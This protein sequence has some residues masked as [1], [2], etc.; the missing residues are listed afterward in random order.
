MYAKQLWRKTAISFIEL[1]QNP[2]PVN[3]NPMTQI[4]FKGSPIHTCGSLPETGAPAP[5]FTLV[6]GDL[7]EVALDTFSGKILVLNIV[8]SLDT[9]VCQASAR[10]FNEI[11]DG[12]DHVVVANVS[13]DLPFAQGRFCG[14]EGLDSIKNLSAFRSPEFGADYGVTITDG[15]L[16]GLLS[17]AVV[18][19]DPDGKVIY[20]EQVPEIAQEPA[21][22][23]VMDHLG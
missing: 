7:E 2:Q 19:V 16:K 5:S 8:P 1:L 6:G 11:V 20:T 15:P 3:R 10:R 23:L 9:G 17:R 12:M 21:Y 14:S 4:L 22:E 13:Q 18:V